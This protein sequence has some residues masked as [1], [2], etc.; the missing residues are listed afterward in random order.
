LSNFQP[1]AIGARAR[2]LIGR[3]LLVPIAVQSA[4][5]A[6]TPNFFALA[7]IVPWERLLA[8]KTLTIA[9]TI[10]TLHS[11]L[12]RLVVLRHY[13]PFLHYCVFEFIT[14]ADH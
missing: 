1:N 9:R 10:F 4:V 8:K 13:R 14:T 12:A 6:H 7:A 3:A 5:Q 2:H 11:T